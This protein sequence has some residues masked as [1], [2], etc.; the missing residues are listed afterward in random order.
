MSSMPSSSRTPDSASSRARLSAVPP[1]IVGEQRVGPL[2]AEHV[3]DRLDVER[4]EIRAVGEAGVG[5]DRRRVRV[6]DDRAE[7]VL[8]QH[9][10]RLAAGVV[11]L[12]GLADHDRAGADDADR[13]DVGSTRQRSSTHFSMSDHA[14]C[15][16]GPASGME[17]ERARAQLREVEAF[18]RAVV[19]R[20]VRRLGGLARAHREAVVLARDEDAAGLRARAPD[21]SR[22]D[23]RTGAC[24]SRGRSR[25]AMSWWPR[26]MPSTGVRPSSSATVFVSRGRAAP[27][28]PGPGE[29]STPSCARER[30]GVDVVRMDGHLRARLREPAEDGVLHA[31]VDDAD[32]DASL[33]GEDVRLGGRD[34]GDERAAEHRRL[35]P[36]ELDRLVDGHVAGDGDR[37]APS[38]PRGDGGRGCACRSR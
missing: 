28:S 10:E 12:G 9:L 18:D 35:L 25:C 38:L 6:D 14:S 33:L 13:L 22:R 32:R 19:E 3:G 37:R 24:T 36:R 2:E 27:G 7:A 16:P 30:V 11:E 4:L 23:G 31:V 8:A 15:G 20:D 26:Q 21:G 29:R 1:P 5:H 17:L 34:A